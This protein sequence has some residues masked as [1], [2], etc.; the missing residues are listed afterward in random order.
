MAND[1]WLMRDHATRFRHPSSVWV[2]A[3]IHQAGAAFSPKRAAAGSRKPGKICADVDRSAHGGSARFPRLRHRDRIGV[4]P[5]FEIRNVCR[6]RL[7]RWSR[8]GDARRGEGSGRDSALIVEPSRLER[9]SVWLVLLSAADLIVTY[10]LMAQGGPFYESNPVAA[11]FFGRWDMAGMTLFKFA[12]IGGVIA[13]GEIIERHRP[14]WGRAVLGLGCLAAALVVI[15][16]L[17][18]MVQAV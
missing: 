5:G 1:G 4:G 6:E 8:G 16:G 12:V 7:A 3:E 15:H 9:E 2:R 10:R 13:L 17:H 14:G 11:W 18:L